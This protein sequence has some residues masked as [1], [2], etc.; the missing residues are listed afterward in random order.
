MKRLMFALVAAM[1]VVGVT[2]AG[3]LHRVN[4]DPVYGYP[5]TY[6]PVEDLN[7]VKASVTVAT[8]GQP[9]CNVN[10][11]DGGAIGGGAA[12]VATIDAYT[13]AKG[14]FTD[15]TIQIPVGQTVAQQT[16]PTKST[17]VYTMPSGTT[18]FRV[19]TRA[20][21]SG[22]PWVG[23]DCFGNKYTVSAGAIEPTPSAEG[24]P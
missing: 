7:V 1:A 22:D 6:N 11:Y 19:Q 5:Q 9:Q 16:G 14:D 4:A 23:V 13:S 20:Y 10:I 12:F 17:L 2:F 8:G 21:T 24:T 3:A 18:A 15:G